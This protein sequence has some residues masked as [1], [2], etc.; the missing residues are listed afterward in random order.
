MTS[1]STNGSTAARA[2][3]ASFTATFPRH[4][5]TDATCSSLFTTFAG[6]ELVSYRPKARRR[7]DSRAGPGDRQTRRARLERIAVTWPDCILSSIATPRGSPKTTIREALPPRSGRRPLQSRAGT[8]AVVSPRRVSRAEDRFRAAVER[9]TR[10]NPNPADGECHYDLGPG[11]RG[12]KQFD[13]AEEAFHKSTWYVGL[14][15]R[16]PI[17][18]WL[19]LPLGA[20]TGRTQRT[21]LRGALNETACHHQATHLLVLALVHQAKTS[22]AATAGQQRTDAR[23]VQLWRTV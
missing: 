14:P 1:C 7:R 8:N 18:N 11:A 4:V 21:L 3:A 12:A 13:E 5:C 17:S 6:S 20:A 15:R 23:S 9:A 16:R 2:F 19:D 22:D 10:H